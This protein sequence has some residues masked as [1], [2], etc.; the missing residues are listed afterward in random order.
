MAPAPVPPSPEERARKTLG[1]IASLAAA[2]RTATGDGDLDVALV[3]ARRLVPVCQA[4][5][6]DA[7]TAAAIA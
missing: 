1:D 2:A 4:L 5:P 6:S 3:L 7:T